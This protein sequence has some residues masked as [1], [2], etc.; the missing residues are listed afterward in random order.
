[1]RLIGMLDSPFVRRVAVSMNL[2]GLPF[3]HESI[4]VFGGYDAF[5]AINPLV[6]APTLVTDDGTVLVDSGVIL[7][8][9]EVLVPERRLTAFAPEDR[10]AAFRLI[11]LGIAACEKAVQLVYERQLR[12]PSNQLASW[13]ERV[14]GQLRQSLD[15]IE[16]ALPKDG[17]GWTF[18]PNALQPDVSCA[19]AWRFVIGKHPGLFEA[20][21]TPALAALSARAEASPEFAASPYDES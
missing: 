7:D 8:Y 12:P 19:I 3:T 9:L 13:E 11:G 2:M 1:M 15:A 21:D 14:I 20:S 16:A 10:V 5:A 4:S 18:G 6:K 17:T